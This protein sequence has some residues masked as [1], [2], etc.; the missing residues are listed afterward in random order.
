MESKLSL[1]LVLYSLGAREFLLNQNQSLTCHFYCII[2]RD[3]YNIIAG[4]YLLSN[5]WSRRCSENDLAE[6]IPAIE[7]VH[8]NCSYKCLAQACWK[9]YLQRRNNIIFINHLTAIVYTRLRLPCPESHNHNYE[10]KWNYKEI[11]IH[12]QYSQQLVFCNNNVVV[13]IFE[14]KCENMQKLSNVQGRDSS[15]QK[16][17]ITGL[18]VE[19]FEVKHI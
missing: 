8:Y 3:S 18:L 15:G 12:S 4:F 6:G 10:I 1:S 9:T 7:V 19:N 16:V 13:C 17:N 2:R 11:S 14:N 5:Q